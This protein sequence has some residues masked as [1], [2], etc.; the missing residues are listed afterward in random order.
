MVTSLGGGGR[1]CFDHE[2]PLALIFSGRFTP[3]DEKIWQI[4]QEKSAARW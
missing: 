3:E 1:G 2:T 4:S